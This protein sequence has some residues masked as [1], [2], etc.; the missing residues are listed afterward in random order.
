MTASQA[1]ATL[2]VHVATLYTYVSRKNIR[3]HK[4]SGVRASRYLKAD[5]ERLKKGQSTEAR[6]ATASGLASSSAVTLVDESGSYYRG[7]SAIELSA[8]GTLEDAA[9][10]LWDTGDFDPFAERTPPARFDELLALTQAYDPP[11]RLAM[12]LPALEAANPR[13]YDLGKH[14]FCRSAA[15]IVRWAGAIFLDR[16][17]PVATPIHRSIGAR[18]RCG[19]AWED[20]VRRVLVLG[21]DQAVHPTTFAVRATANTGA[22]PYRCVLAGLAAVAGKRLPSVRTASFASF[23]GDI[24]RAADPVAPIKTRRRKNEDLPGFGFSPFETAD[25][26]AL[27]L[28]SAMQQGL[29]H[30]KRFRHFDRAIQFGCDATGQPPDFSFLA[31]YVSYRV[32]LGQGANLLRLARLVGWLAHSLEQ[33]LDRPMLRWRVTY[34]GRLPLEN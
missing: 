29:A 5:I 1:A 10:L 26:R 32:G 27:A 13:A 8:A 15:Q 34:T 11:D 20:M 17:R 12:L 2:G 6:R 31:A 21:A 28:W 33:Q 22:T 9:R 25:P 3:T 23:I 24:E 7:I 14:G 19:R 4:L 18:S 30:D 16:M